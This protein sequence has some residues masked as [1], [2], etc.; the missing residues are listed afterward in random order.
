[1]TLTTCQVW[2]SIMYTW[3]MLHVYSNYFRKTACE[4]NTDNLFIILMVEN[5]HRDK[6]F[7]LLYFFAYKAEHTLFMLCPLG[8]V[9]CFFCRLLIFFQ[10][11][12]FRKILS[13]RPSECQ[14]DWIQVRPDKKSGLIWVQ[15]VCKSNQQTTLGDKELTSCSAPATNLG[16]LSSRPLL[17]IKISENE[18]PSIAKP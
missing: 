9:S 14:T 15:T 12:L 3:Y 6:I 1:M 4:I 7:R 13:G 5:E 16:F 11:E 17:F 2:S 18:T 10:N 8:S